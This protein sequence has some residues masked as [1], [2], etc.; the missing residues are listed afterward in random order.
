MDDQ[1]EG[2]PEGL[3][4]DPTTPEQTEAGSTPAPQAD[5]GLEAGVQ[6]A[7]EGQASPQAD[8]V[9]SEVDPA[10]DEY[11]VHPTAPA[12]FDQ[13]SDSPDGTSK[14][15]PLS[16][17]YDLDLPISIEL[18]RARMSV[19]DVLALARGSVVQLD[20][21]AGEPVDVYVGNRRFAEGEVVIVG[22]QFGVRITR[23]V[24][25]APTTIASAG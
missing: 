8:P 11:A 4:T 7:E 3:P 24:N 22:E 9:G 6:V 23:I 13:L 1:N 15:G 12:D 14:P 25:A 16:M 5:P 10:L 21:Q 18:G 17:L 2:I 19:Q 20:R